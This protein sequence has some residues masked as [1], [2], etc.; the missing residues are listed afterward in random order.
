MHFIVLAYYIQIRYYLRE[1]KT[2]D[3]CET[4]RKLGQ[5]CELLERHKERVIL[6]LST[7]PTNQMIWVVCPN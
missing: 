2:T 7:Q 6:L 5:C 1:G 4:V 3:A